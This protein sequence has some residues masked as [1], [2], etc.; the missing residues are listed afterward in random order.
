M[1]DTMLYLLDSLMQSQEKIVLKLVTEWRSLRMSSV[2]PSWSPQHSHPRPALYRRPSTKASAE[3][4]R[5]RGVMKA[6]LQT[7]TKESPLNVLN[8]VWFWGEGNGASSETWPLP[9]G[10]L[11]VK[12]PHNLYQPPLQKRENTF[13]LAWIA[14]YTLQPV[15]RDHEIWNHRHFIRT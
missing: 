12:H 13:K 1:G 3:A 11:D 9:R 6:L 10:S 15:D 4:I 7:I 8:H 2:Q 5:G 14:I